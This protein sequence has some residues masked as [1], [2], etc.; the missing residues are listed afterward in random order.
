M[1]NSQE[2][3]TE[4]AETRMYCDGA[5]VATIPI[6]A[7]EWAAPFK[8]FTAGNH[9]CSVTVVDITGEESAPTGPLFFDVPADQPEPAPVLNVR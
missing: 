3:L 2:P 4:L 9:S 5:L 7:Q 6:P 1:G 8:F